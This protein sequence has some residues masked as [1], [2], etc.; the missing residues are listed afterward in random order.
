MQINLTGKKALVTGSSKGIGLAIAKALHAEGCDIAF[1]SR[2][3]E[4][5][6]HIAKQFP[7]SIAVAGDV[8]N[9]KD[10]NRII[11]EVIKSFGKLDILVCNVGGGSSVLFADET[12][13]DWQRIF[14]LN[15]WSTINI[16]SAAKNELALNSGVIICISSICGL[17]VVEGAPISYSAAKAALH[18][19]VRGMARP[20]GKQGI[21]INAIA[22]GNILFD[23]SVWSRKLIENNT[24]VKA[25]LE[26]KVSLGVLGKPED[27]AN[28]TTYL[29]SDIASFVTGT[30]WTIDGGQVHG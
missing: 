7:G 30:V 8:T 15:L 4:E 21:R 25:M 22:P 28:L 18:S 16:V 27:V 1:N 14:S 26:E 19:Y 10:A 20:L 6:I 29:V 24:A 12:G 13:E 23:N 5:L 3:S 9:Q 17:E 11:M 2:N